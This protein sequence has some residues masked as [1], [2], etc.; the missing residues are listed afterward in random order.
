MKYNATL[1]TAWRWRRALADVEDVWIKAEPRR[2]RADPFT[3]RSKQLPRGLQ[4]CSHLSAQRRNT[5]AARLPS[6]QRSGPP[7]LNTSL[8]GVG[9]GGGGISASGTFTSHTPSFRRPPAQI[10]LLVIC[11]FPRCISRHFSLL[12]M[13]RSTAFSMSSWPVPGTGRVLAQQMERKSGGE[14]FVTVFVGLQNLTRFVIFN[15][16]KSSTYCT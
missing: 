5:A 11:R 14:L 13:G 9:G 8:V 6:D 1:P 10:L 12:T 4:A 16:G 15:I 2:G 7:R 3:L